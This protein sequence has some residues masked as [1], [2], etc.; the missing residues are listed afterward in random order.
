MDTS[1]EACR[2]S[3]ADTRFGFSVR[4][5]RGI[6]LISKPGEAR[7]GYREVLAIRRHDPHWSGTELVGRRDRL[8]GTNRAEPAAFDEPHPGK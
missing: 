4:T 2:I 7:D 3:D 1:G 5:T 8:P 6:G